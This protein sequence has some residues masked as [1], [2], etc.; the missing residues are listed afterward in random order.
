MLLAAAAS[1]LAPEQA[2]RSLPSSNPAQTEANLQELRILE[3]VYKIKSGK[4]EIDSRFG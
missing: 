2:A 4:I 3:E 1:A